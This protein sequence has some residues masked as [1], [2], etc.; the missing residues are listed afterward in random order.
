MVAPVSRYLVLKSDSTLEKV[1]CYASGDHDEC[2]ESL[3]SEGAIVID[4]DISGCGH[5]IDSGQWIK[6]E[7]LYSSRDTRNFSKRFCDLEG[8]ARIFKS[9]KPKETYEEYRKRILGRNVEPKGW[10]RKF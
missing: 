7:V 8:D 4:W 5:H 3:K 1:I 10:R 2:M 6:D 9:A